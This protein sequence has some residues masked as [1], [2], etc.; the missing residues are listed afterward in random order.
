MDKI[1][2][3]L[4]KT[5]VIATEKLPA[6]QPFLTQF[7]DRMVFHSQRV[8]ADDQ[9]LIIRVNAAR[10]LERLAE[11]NL[12]AVAKPLLEV[13]KNPQ[14]DPSVKYYALMGLKELLRRSQ[15]PDSKVLASD[16]G[17]K[18]AA[19]A[20][21]AAMNVVE[22]KKEVPDTYSPEQVEGVR[23]VRREAIRAVAAGRR[24]VL[25]DQKGSPV[26]PAQLL[27][28]VM[29]DSAIKPEPRIDERV[30]A[31][32]GLA[33]M[34]SRAEP[35]YQPDYAAIQLGQFVVGFA[36]E[37]DEARSKPLL[38]PWKIYAARLSD[39]LEVLRKENAESK[40]IDKKTAQFISELVDKAKPVLKPIEDA[41]NSEP[42]GFQQWLNTNKARANT[43]LLKGV[44]DSPAKETPDK[45]EP[46]KP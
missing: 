23:L 10:L 15:T 45:N 42:S 11:S 28:D 19:A 2:V 43:S 4:D 34:R 24:P 16:E 25:A 32:I 5:L 27:L 30:E 21:L 44:A 46:T 31:A 17:K 36:K 26:Y 7:A 3:D 35:L 40:Q 20:I 1:W 22:P 18:N 6:T 33:Q 29:H 38:H 14:Q 39:A 9:Y 12:D 13:V 41:N 37:F 8:L